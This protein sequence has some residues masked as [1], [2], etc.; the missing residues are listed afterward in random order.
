[1]RLFTCLDNGV[2]SAQVMQSPKPYNI[3]RGHYFFCV[4]FEVWKVLRPEHLR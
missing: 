1:M 2:F 4:C 3:F